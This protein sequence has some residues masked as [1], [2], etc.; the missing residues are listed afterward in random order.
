MLNIPACR[1][2]LESV[3][4]GRNVFFTGGAGTGKSFLVHKI[5]GVTC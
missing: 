2:V 3:R 1:Y 5:I 4:S